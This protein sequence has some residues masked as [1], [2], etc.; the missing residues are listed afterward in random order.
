MTAAAP[1][2]QKSRALIGWRLLALFYDF[3]PV[4][5]MW[6]LVGL[7]FVL[8]F[9]A[10]GHDTHENIRPL[11]GWWWGEWLVCWM[12]AGLYATVSWRRGGQTLGMRPWRLKVIAADGSAPSRKQLWKRYAVATLSLLLGG[13]GF[14]WAWFDKDRLA[15]HDRL[16]DTRTIRLPKKKA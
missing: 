2:T 10:A 13:L 11:S 3:W 5:A 4:L 6:M 12:V 7:A 16:S 8:L 1:G 9:T 15:W 14:W